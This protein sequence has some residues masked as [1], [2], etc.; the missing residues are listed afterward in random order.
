[1]TR[2]TKRDIEQMVRE[3]DTVDPNVSVSSSVVVV[4]GDGTTPEPEPPEGY[5]LADEIPT[6]SPV[7]DCH[8]LEPIS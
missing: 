6:Q 1:M 7:V 8:E 2:P 5:T 4:T 3:L